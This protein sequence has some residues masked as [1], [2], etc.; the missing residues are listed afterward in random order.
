MN[1]PEHINWP[2]G[3]DDQRFLTEY[4]QKKPLLIR[5]AFADF[6]TPV[7]PDELAGMSLEEETTPRLITQDN[8]GAYHLENGPFDEARFSTLDA[9]NWSLLVTDVEKHFPDLADYLTPFDFIP[10]WRIDDLMISYAPDG[11]SVGAHVDEYDVFLLQA[12]GTRKWMIDASEQPDLQL[13]PDATLKLLANFQA[14]DTYLLEPGDM[15]YLPPGMPHHGVAVGEDCT[16]WSVG[17]RAPILSEAINFFSE[18][19]AS[20]FE[21]QR[22]TDPALSISPPGEI[23]AQ[24]LASFKAL[25]EKAST[26][27]D[28][29]LAT[30][31]GCLLTT[32]PMDIEREE[33]D[34][35]QAHE[36]QWIKHSF[37]RLAYTNSSTNGAETAELF[38]DGEA[39]SCSLEFAMS[40]CNKQAVSFHDLNEQDTQALIRLIDAG[41]LLPD[42]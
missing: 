31:T 38:A 10:N 28:A 22:Y 5:Q 32:S 15:L 39:L 25:W 21:Q 29:Q 42:A 34:L 9:N 11:A 4:W 12:G 27:S 3:L 30:M 7:S 40:I 17:F 23:N 14:S 24:T 6:E 19:V 8:S 33:F 20:E 26:L 36:H 13:V 2:D 35:N 18:T 1:V 16:T 37:S 41:C